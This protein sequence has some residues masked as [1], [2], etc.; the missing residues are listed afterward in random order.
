MAPEPFGVG[1]KSCHGSGTQRHHWGACLQH[2][3][4]SYSCLGVRAAVL[5]G[6]GSQLDT[7]RWAVCWQCVWSMCVQPRGD[8]IYLQAEEFWSFP[9]Q[10]ST[11][12]QVEV[13]L[14]SWYFIGLSSCIA[15][16]MCSSYI[17]L[18]L[19][20]SAS[21]YLLLKNIYM[22]NVLKGERLAKLST[23]LKILSKPFPA[24]MK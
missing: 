23:G 18:L 7:L 6:Q 9:V 5:R 12:E 24:S 13:R 16:F 20:H 22:K 3:G 15:S 2:G 1:H 17:S 11:R 10:A 8:Q 19:H 14:Q 4:S 21:L